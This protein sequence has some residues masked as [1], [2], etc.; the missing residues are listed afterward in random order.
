MLYLKTIN[1]LCNRIRAI[2][3]AIKLTRSVPG[4]LCVL[5]PRQGRDM[6]VGFKELF[7][8]PAEF[9]LVDADDADLGPLMARFA[10]GE[11]HFVSQAQMADRAE[12]ERFVKRYLDAPDEDWFLETH[13]EFVHELTFSWMKPRPEIEAEVRR[14]TAE[15]QG[16]CI[17]VHIRRTDNLPATIYSPDHLFKD[18]IR[19]ELEKNGNVRFFVAS[20]DEAIK[21]EL[22][23][24][25]GDHVITRMK[26]ASR[27]Q[28]G[29]VVQGLVD[30]LL[31]SR[32]QKIYASYWS[33]F[34]TYAARI[35][36]IQ[37]I[38]VKD[39]DLEA[40]LQRAVRLCATLNWR[41]LQMKQ[42][43][44]DLHAEIAGVLSGRPKMICD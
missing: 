43:Y 15:I 8:S 35:G 33:S 12:R 27:S 40:T 36:G 21:R 20:D 6:N 41:L 32:T 10:P 23:Q 38:C 39:T 5:W 19:Q 37:M 42:K 28:Q 30:L 9:R 26:L 2:S 25:F 3:A 44:N 7:L 11:A 24:E 17:G 14:V 13:E 22:V 31:L 29:G 18:V 4:D 16:G 34:S 1:G